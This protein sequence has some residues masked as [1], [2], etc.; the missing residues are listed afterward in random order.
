MAD[1][2]PLLL[3]G[4]CLVALILARGMV[5]LAREHV[6]THHAAWYA[7]LGA[8]G[9]ALRLGGP[10]ERARRRLARPLI[11]GPLPPAAASDPVLRKIVDHLRLAMAAAG[12]SMAGLVAILA[13][14]AHL[15]A[16]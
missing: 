5:M 10:D 7:E 15:G 9:S 1:I 6:R 4:L 12:L 14:R 2:A 16:A 3:M 13:L 8:A 11:F